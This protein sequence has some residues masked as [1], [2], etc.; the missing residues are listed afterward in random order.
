MHRLGREEWTELVSEYEKSNLGQREFAQQH[1]VS[2]PSLQFWLYKLRREA[3]S[4]RRFL[5]VSVVAPAPKA[6]LA[7]PDWMELQLPSGLQ[8][9][10]AVG[11]NCRYV[12]NLLVALA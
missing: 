1:E 10:F 5:P 4:S 6:R 8:L 7:M 12:A 9:R 11:T 2:V 3:N